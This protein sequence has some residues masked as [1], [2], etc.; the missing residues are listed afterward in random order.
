LLHEWVPWR[1]LGGELPLAVVAAEDQKFAEHYGFD[2]ESIV[3]AMKQNAES[4]SLRGGSTISQ[5]VAKNLFLWPGRSYLRKGVE[6]W[7]TL[8]IEALWPKRRVLEV[9]LNV[10][11]FGPGVYGS[12][13]A[14]EELFGTAPARLGA[15]QAALMAAVLPSPKRLRADQPSAY[16]LERQRWIL[17][18]MR[19]LRQSDWLAQMD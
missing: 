15:E 1:D 19:R 6:A 3:D 11:E 14:A 5:Q 12:G 13:A 10:A 16:L 7:F 4:G 8:L 17:V 9:Y 2:L 18:H